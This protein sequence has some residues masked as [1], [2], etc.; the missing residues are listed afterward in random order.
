MHPHTY[1]YGNNKALCLYTRAQF[2]LLESYLQMVNLAK[3][4]DLKTLGS[5]D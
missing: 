5:L 1:F 4:V 3:L 2:S